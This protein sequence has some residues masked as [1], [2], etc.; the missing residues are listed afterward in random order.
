MS[1]HTSPLGVD[2]AMQEGVDLRKGR[3]WIAAVMSVGHLLSSAPQ[4]ANAVE[5]PA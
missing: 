3:V 2:S 4:K 5:M 1:F